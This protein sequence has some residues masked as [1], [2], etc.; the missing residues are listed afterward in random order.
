MDD[1][2]KRKN[3]RRLSV[4]SF[5]DKQE[6]AEIIDLVLAPVCHILNRWAGDPVAV[7]PVTNDEETVC[8]QLIFKEKG[9]IY[10]R[11]WRWW[12]Q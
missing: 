1:E 3:G 2:I 10:V 11:W 7:V 6:A 9:D 5:E 4:A 8:T 12:K